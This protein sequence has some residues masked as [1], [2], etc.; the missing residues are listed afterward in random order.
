M[1]VLNTLKFLNGVDVDRV[2]VNG[3]MIVSALGYL[4]RLELEEIGERDDRAAARRSRRVSA[5]NMPRDRF[6]ITFVVRPEDP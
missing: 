1:G 6:G 3:T 4:R 5:Y 2:L